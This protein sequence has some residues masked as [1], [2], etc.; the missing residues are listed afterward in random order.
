[1]NRYLVTSDIDLYLIARRTKVDS[2]LIGSRSER[3]R[4]FEV[5]AKIGESG[6]DETR[7]ARCSV[8]NG[9]LED[10]E[11]MDAGKTIY[12]MHK[13]WKRLLEGKSLDEI[14]YPL[15]RS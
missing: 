1:M 4:L 8:C 12:Y 9:Q 15:S 10:S 6:I 11:R 7:V 14:V 13:L 5:L 2:I 3:E